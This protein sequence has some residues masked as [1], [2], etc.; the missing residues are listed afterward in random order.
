[1]FRGNVFLV[2][3]LWQIAVEVFGK[4]TV[5]SALHKNAPRKSEAGDDVL[6]R[7]KE[8]AAAGWTEMK[9][10]KAMRGTQQILAKLLHGGKV[11]WSVFSKAVEIHAYLFGPFLETAP[12]TSKRE[13]ESA[14]I[15]T[16]KELLPLSGDTGS[17]RVAK[18][19][20]EAIR[21]M[22]SV[23]A[24]LESGVLQERLATPIKE[25]K[26]KSNN[27][28]PPKQSLVR[29]EIVLEDIIHKGL[30]GKGGPPRLP[31]ELLVEFGVSAFENSTP[32]LR[33]IG[34]KILLA[35]YEINGDRVRDFLPEDD[36]KVRKTHITYRKLFEEFDRIDKR[37]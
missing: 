23:E 9:P 17:E 35:L 26:K 3:F 29:A 25:D 30:V 22:L 7:L 36:V 11:V 16:Y 18:R 12:K 4:S 24:V 19:S 27:S 5:R 21:T 20:K 10:G 15:K 2:N 1:M 32:V 13:I 28:E 14:A 31:L 33:K 6:R 37:K 8:L 34:E